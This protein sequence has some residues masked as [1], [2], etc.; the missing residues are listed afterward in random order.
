AGERENRALL[1]DAAGPVGERITDGGGGED[2]RSQPVSGSGVSARVESAIRGE[3]G[4][5][6]GRAP[7]GGGSALPGK[8]S[9]PCGNAQGDERLHDRVARKALADRERADPAG[10]ARVNNS[11]RRA[12]GRKTDGVHRR[13]IRSAE[14]MR[15]GGEDVSARSAAAATAICACARREP[16]DGWIQR[17]ESG[18]E[19]GQKSAVDDAGCARGGRQRPAAARSLIPFPVSPRGKAGAGGFPPRRKKRGSPHKRAAAPL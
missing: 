8:H 4:Q 9:Q 3:G 12:A 6:R 13:G 2:R 1:R 5:R 17:A 11:N 14:C 18:S 7:A 19:S 15:E 10:I 16:L